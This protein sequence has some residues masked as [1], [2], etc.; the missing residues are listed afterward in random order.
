MA[1][2]PDS[3]SDQGPLRDRS[4]SRSS[5]PNPP[6]S[7]QS[8]ILR[9]QSSLELDN[10]AS[11]LPAVPPAIIQDG[12]NQS[13]GPVIHHQRELSTSSLEIGHDHEISRPARTATVQF[14][15]RPY[16]R[17]LST[18]LERS[19]YATLRS[20][21]SHSSSKR[22]FTPVHIDPDSKYLHTETTPIEYARRVRAFSFDEGALSDSRSKNTTDGSSSEQ[23][24]SAPTHR[25][26]LE[27]AVSP[28]LPPC[29]PL[30]RVS[31]P[32]GLPRWPNDV[33]A[34]PGGQNFR[35]R[36][37]PFLALSGLI[38]RASGSNE[39]LQHRFWRPMPGSGTPGFDELE[40]HPFNVDETSPEA[41][42]SPASRSLSLV[43]GATL[44]RPSSN[45]RRRASGT[46]ARQS[47]VASPATASLP[48]SLEIRNNRRAAES[49]ETSPGTAD[50][51]SQL[52]RRFPSPPE[53]PRPSVSGGHFAIGHNLPP[54]SPVLLP[55]QSPSDDGASN[56]PLDLGEAL[57]V[58]HRADSPLAGRINT[59]TGGSGPARRRE[60]CG[61]ESHAS[62]SGATRGNVE[63]RYARSG[64]PIYRAD[65]A[66]DS[67]IPC[68]RAGLDQSDEDESSAEP[69]I[70]PEH[71]SRQRDVGFVSPQS[72]NA[73]PTPRDVAAASLSS[74]QL[75][76][77]PAISNA[78][79][80]QQPSAAT[81]MLTSLDG[82][83]RD[84]R[85]REGSR[86]DG[87]SAYSDAQRAAVSH[88]E[89]GNSAKTLHMTNVLPR[90]F[91]WLFAPCLC[92]SRRSDGE[93]TGDADANLSRPTS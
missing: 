1:Q 24:S 39:R 47:R 10:P 41:I 89:K 92:P 48:R 77:S 58:I 80:T 44:I 76:N 84:E 79:R 61:D 38:R 82:N 25:P 91:T 56:S 55:Q 50:D 8:K 73:T 13:D 68:T 93:A 18:I 87:E 26:S 11:G 36:S 64:V 12:T 2:V 72:E 7:V 85:H 4:N 53:S 81:P 45:P 63:Q 71:P 46:I 14:K 34:S 90:L 28:A 51:T 70:T 33:R 83:V 57:H 15:N 66:S 27:D 74:R 86:D 49:E 21:L 59:S 23:P 75:F 22:R 31:T 16:G 35:R 69:M 19:S 40:R 60:G 17:P 9:S 37:N 43:L 32:Q 65:A 88:Q 42:E 29:E 30:Q 3:Q 52:I 6:A 20:R 62:M 78:R 67:T 5:S 54:S